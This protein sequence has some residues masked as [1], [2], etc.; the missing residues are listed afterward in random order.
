MNNKI[1]LKNNPYKEIDFQLPEIDIP[2]PNFLKVFGER[3]EKI[4]SLIL[5]CI[6]IEELNYLKEND[7]LKE[8]FSIIEDSFDKKMNRAILSYFKNED[9]TL[10]I[11]TKLII[12]EE[13]LEK[14]LQKFRI[15]QK[16]K[17]F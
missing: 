5:E 3:E 17:G 10:N 11:E 16:I 12:D 4:K 1:K 9:F 15:Q 7:L 8:C 14:H 2:S 6:T 13:N